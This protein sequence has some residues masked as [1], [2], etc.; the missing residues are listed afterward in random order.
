MTIAILLRKHFFTELNKN[1][2]SYGMI[3]INYNYDK[4]RLINSKNKLEFTTEKNIRKEFLTFQLEEAIELK[5]VSTEDSK[6]T[7]ITILKLDEDIK[8]HVV[9]SFSIQGLQ[10]FEK[11]KTLNPLSIQVINTNIRDSISLYTKSNYRY[12][13]RF[14][15]NSLL[16]SSAIKEDTKTIFII[17]NDLIDAKQILINCK[18]FQ[19]IGMIYTSEIKNWLEIKKQSH[20]VNVKLT[21]VIIPIAAKHFA[22]SFETQDFNNLL[23]FEYSLISDKGKLIEFVDGETKV[24]A[25]NFSIQIIR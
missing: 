5:K 25:L 20:W 22:F 8:K 11:F 6:M 4:K 15:A 16:F 10:K 1:F 7:N 21:D 19:A 12:K 13:F 18:L 17:P 9:T 24:P 14:I 3:S 23:N 2:S